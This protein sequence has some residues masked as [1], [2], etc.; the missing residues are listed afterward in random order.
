MLRNGAEC[1]SAAVAMSDDPRTRKRAGIFIALRQS[2][3]SNRE[4]AQG[5][6]PV[7]A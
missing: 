3:G 1:M 7:D 2:R 6:M 4:A 5:R